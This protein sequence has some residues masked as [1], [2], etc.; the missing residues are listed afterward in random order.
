MMRGVPVVAIHDD[1]GRWAV[2]AELEARK[3]EIATLRGVVAALRDSAAARRAREDGRSKMALR[4]RLAVAAV[5][6]VLM[7]F[8]LAMAILHWMRP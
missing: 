4:V 8:A 1:D 2:H 5:A 3:E 6:G 7:G